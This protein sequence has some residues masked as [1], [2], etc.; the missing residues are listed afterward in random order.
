MRFVPNN[1]AIFAIGLLTVVI[2]FGCNADPNCR[3]EI[4]LMR[5]EILDLEDQNALLRSRYENAATELSTYTGQP[6]DLTGLGPTGNFQSVVIEDFASG[7]NEIIPG[8]IYSDPYVDRYATPD[9]AYAAPDGIIIEDFP[10]TAAPE[11]SP[12]DAAPLPSPTPATRQPRLDPSNLPMAKPPA[13]NPANQLPLPESLR[14][15]QGRTKGP[16]GFYNARFARSGISGPMATEIAIHRTATRGHSVDNVPGDEGLSLLIQPKS[17]RGQIIMESGELTV[18]L[19]NPKAI[20]GE[21]RIGR[22]K[23]LP[24]ETELFFVND[25][26]ASHGILLNLPWSLNTPTHPKLVVHARLTTV[27]GRV[28]QTS[29]EVRIRPPSSNYSPE[30]PA[31][32]AWTQQDWRWQSAGEADNPSDF[33]LVSNGENSVGGDDIWRQ[34]SQSPQRKR[35][36]ATPASSSRT[37][38]PKP[39]WRPVR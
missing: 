7:T 19:I 6:V 11:M 31:V 18:S 8:E 36:K 22:W 28:L 4:A 27:D 25:E 15:N 5:S 26:L 37:G 29:K 32:V 20:P 23:F 12:T 1:L 10:A 39:G 16:S 3:R 35:V 21:Q 38:P 33:E 24:E 2:S 17:S 14:D 34:T 9:A 30:D 13:I